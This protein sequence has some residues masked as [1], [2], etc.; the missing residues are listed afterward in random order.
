MPGSIVTRPAVRLPVKPT[1]A[2]FMVAT[3]SVLDGPSTTAVCGKAGDTI[4]TSRTTAH[5]RAFMAE[6]LVFSQFLPDL[7]GPAIAVHHDPV[8]RLDHIQRVAIELRD[9][10]HAHDHRA[11]SEERRVG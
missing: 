9:A 6:I 1:S 11:R 2:R 7:D 5:T 4:A 8:A 3:D 10:R